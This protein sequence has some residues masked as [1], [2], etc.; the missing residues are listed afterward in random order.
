MGVEVGQVLDQPTLVGLSETINREHAA[1]EACLQDGIGHAISAGE[2]LIS[3]KEAVPRGEWVR[4]VGAN[5]DTGI[6]TVNAYVRLAVFRDQ[7]PEGLR[8]VADA[9]RFLSEAGLLRQVGPAPVD[10]DQDEA[11]R[12][13]AGGLSYKKIGECLGVSDTT[14]RLCLDEHARKKARA[15]SAQ[16]A[17]RR[18]AAERALRREEQDRAVKA[19][20]FSAVYAGI[21][22][23]TD[24]VGAFADNAATSEHRA[25]ANAALARLHEARDEIVKGLGL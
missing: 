2:A 3:A 6:A 18:R 17:R 14:V 20:P 23:L 21:H 7:L 12:L 16:H 8:H 24:R 1:V 10:L 19:T 5:L 22:D 15:R 13:R 9:R 25:I 4:W 11:R